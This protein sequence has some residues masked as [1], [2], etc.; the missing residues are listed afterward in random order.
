MRACRTASANVPSGHRRT[1]SS[2]AASPVTDPCEGAGHV[3]GTAVSSTTLTT[4]GWRSRRSSAAGSTDEGHEGDAGEGLDV[5][6][7][8]ARQCAV[9]GRRDAR[10]RRRARRGSGRSPRSGRHERRP[11]PGGGRREPAAGR[12]LWPV[13]AASLVVSSSAETIIDGIT[14]GAGGQR[15]QAPPRDRPARRRLCHARRSACSAAT[16]CRRA[17]H[18]ERGQHVDAP[19]GDPAAA[20]RDAGAGERRPGSPARWRRA[21]PA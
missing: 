8:R 6:D 12:E 15:D 10:G 16:G 18:V 4:S 3:G 17:Q 19:L 14:D 7:A 2:A 9:C 13:P 21:C 1:V 11:A 5:G 20:H